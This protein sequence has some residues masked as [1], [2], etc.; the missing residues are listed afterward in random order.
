M[1]EEIMLIVHFGPASAT[2]NQVQSWQASL[3]WAR[4]YHAYNGRLAFSGMLSSTTAWR[5]KR[6][7]GIQ[8]VIKIAQ[9]M[10]REG[11]N[12]AVHWLMLFGIALLPLGAVDT[13]RR[14]RS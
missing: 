7:E 11:Q 9:V 1:L 3:D 6:Q 2:R 10:R 8:A 12:R 14:H 4:K 5:A 13:W